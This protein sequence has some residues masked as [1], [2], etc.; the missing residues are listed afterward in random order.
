MNKIMFLLLILL[1]QIFSEPTWWAENPEQLIPLLQIAIPLGL[2]MGV[3]LII[4]III[5]SIVQAC[6]H[7]GKIT[8]N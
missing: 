4:T 3:P 2:V 8:A 5:Y 6:K 7:G 1:S